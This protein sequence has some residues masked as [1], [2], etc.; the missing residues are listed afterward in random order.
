MLTGNVK[1]LVPHFFNKGKYVPHHENLQFYIGLGLKLKQ[2]HSVLEFN[3]LQWL[4]PHVEF[5][6]RKRIAAE[7]MV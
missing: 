7:K 3:R 1:K 6:T 5:N 4:K 2:I